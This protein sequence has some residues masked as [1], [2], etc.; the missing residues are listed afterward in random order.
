[1]PYH[2]NKKTFLQTWYDEVPFPR[3]DYWL[4]ARIKN[5]DVSGLR[6]TTKFGRR[7][8]ETEQRLLGVPQDLI[9]AILGHTNSRI[10]DVYMDWTALQ[11]DIRD[12]METRHYM[13]VN[14]ILS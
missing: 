9:D 4:T 10:G 8:C 13:L 5:Y 3:P 7:T 6:V 11:S 2:E 14:G 1:M 12:V